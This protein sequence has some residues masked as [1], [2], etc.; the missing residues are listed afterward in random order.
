MF[1]LAIG[2]ALSW[3]AMFHR[4]YLLPFWTRRIRREIDA[5]TENT[6]ATS[7]A[8]PF[9]LN[10]PAEIFLLGPTDDTEW[11]AFTLLNL[12]REHGK[13]NHEAWLVSWLN[14][15]RST[16]IRG[17]LGVL[18]ALANLK[19]DKLPPHSGYDHPHY[20]D[21][22][23]ISRA[24]PIGVFWAGNSA[25]AA[26]TAGRDAQ[27]TNAEDGLWAAQAMAAGIS[28]ACRGE[29][30][31]RVLHHA[32]AQLPEESWIGRTVAE[33]LAF[34]D[35][36]KPAFEII[37]HLSATAINREYNYG[38]VAPETFALT[39]AIVKQ[40]Q[41]QFENAIML[42]TAF[43]KTADSVPAF[44]G[45]LCG[46]LTNREILFPSWQERLRKLHGIC[47]PALAEVNFMESVE[48]LAGLAVERNAA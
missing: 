26:A 39:L 41:G 43:A 37:P 7:L 11:A 1:G 30:V 42:A 20:F 38:N 6:N 24:V 25:R 18:A 21:D 23:A 22:S 3:P 9:S 48:Q 4:S 47:I 8:M 27:I 46:A 16:N 14:L 13:I 17:S 2:D 19:K 36:Q 31:E 28:A 12:L 44:T 10:R 35:T 15:A 32:R 45:A 40:T 29:S 33:A 34:C 5:E